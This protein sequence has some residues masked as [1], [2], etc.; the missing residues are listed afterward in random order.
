MT[1]TLTFSPGGSGTG[2]AP[3]GIHH[4]P[5]RSTRSLSAVSNPSRGT[6]SGIGLAAIG[7]SSI[8]RTGSAGAAASAASAEASDPAP[9]PTEPAAPTGPAAPRGSG[10][11]VGTASAASVGPIGRTAAGSPP[12]PLVPA[13]RGVVARYRLLLRVCRLM[14]TKASARSCPRERWSP[15]ARAEAAMA[16]RVAST[17]KASERGMS[18]RISHTPVPAWRGRDT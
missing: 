6:P 4:G 9:A 17:R 13:V 1:S 2:S 3:D 12:P 7:P 10:G 11:A 14:A 8:G 16:S 5:V 18:M 15:T